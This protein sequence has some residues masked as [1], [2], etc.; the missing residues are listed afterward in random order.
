MTTNAVLGN[1]RPHIMLKLLL[2]RRRSGRAGS[3]YGGNRK[4]GRNGSELHPETYYFMETQYP[5]QLEDTE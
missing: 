1:E 5:E 2:Q 4:Q 3:R